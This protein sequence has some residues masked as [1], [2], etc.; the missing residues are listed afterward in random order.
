[1]FQTPKGAL[2][3]NHMLLHFDRT[4]LKK[5]KTEISLETKILQFAAIHF[6]PLDPHKNVLVSYLAPCLQPLVVWKVTKGCE[7]AT[8]Q[9]V[10]PSPDWG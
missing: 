8:N 1:M 4:S 7:R 2:N 10:E 9:R 5:K 6:I 3:L